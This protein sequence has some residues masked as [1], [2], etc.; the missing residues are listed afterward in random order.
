MIYEDSVGFWRAWK[1]LNRSEDS[2]PARIEGHS[3]SHDI[4]NH[5]ADMFL[6]STTTRTMMLILSIHL[7]QNFTRSFLNTTDAHLFDNIS[8]YLF[9]WNDMKDM[10]SRLRCE[11]NAML[12]L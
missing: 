2:L 12:A 11:K 9:S 10:A 8:H 1:S 5:F 7:H 3:S 4:G 6:M